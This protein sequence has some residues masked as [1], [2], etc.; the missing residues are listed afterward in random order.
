MRISER[1]AWRSKS[2]PYIVGPHSETGSAC[3]YTMP[4]VHNEHP[5]EFFRILRVAYAKPTSESV[6]GKQTLVFISQKVE[7]IIYNR[8]EQLMPRA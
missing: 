2:K 7:D 1:N 5:M 4:G 3:F 6:T 8:K